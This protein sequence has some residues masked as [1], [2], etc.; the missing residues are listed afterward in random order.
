M[1]NANKRPRT[2]N[3]KGLAMEIYN[4]CKANDLWSDNTIYFKGKAWTN[5]EKWGGVKGKYIAED[6][7]EYDDKNPRDYFEYGNEPNIL[8]M[9]FEGPLNYVLNAYVD[10]WVEL[11][12]E[13]AA[14]FNRHGLYYEMGYAWSL[15][16][17]E[18]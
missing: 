6:L 7:Y 12:Q 9:S 3:T 4:W 2:Y 10:G 14:L 1:T 17:Y 13:F 11:E 15:S 8:A 5:L 18:N 16:A